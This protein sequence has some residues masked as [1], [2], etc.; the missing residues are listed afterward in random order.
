M[1][2]A[3]KSSKINISKESLT[4]AFAKKFSNILK[5][6]DVVYLYGEIG[7]GKTTFIKYLINTIQ[8]KKNVKLSEIT[9]PTFSIMNEYVIKDIKIRHY[10]LFRIKNSIEIKNI[11][12]YENSNN[13]ITLVEWPEKISKKLKIKYNLFFDYNFK[14]GKRFIKVI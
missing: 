13:F 8:M 5:N 3:T 10:D 7:V 14:N 9:S 4:A 6:G 1:R 12:L 2:I 11:G